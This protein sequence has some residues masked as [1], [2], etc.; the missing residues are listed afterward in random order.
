MVP[1]WPQAWPVVQGTARSGVSLGSVAGDRLRLV[2]RESDIKGIFRQDIG[3]EFFPK[4]IGFERKS[5]FLVFQWPGHF[6]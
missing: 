1:R 2:G 6:L 4:Y 3:H 5:R